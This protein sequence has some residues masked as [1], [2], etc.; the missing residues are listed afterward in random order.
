MDVQS[1]GNITA[2]DFL[3][4]YNTGATINLIDVRRASEYEAQHIAGAVS[5][6][7]DFINQ[8]MSDYKANERYY[9]Q[10]ASGYRSMIAAS[11]LQARG[12]EEVINVQGG[13]KALS[14]L[15]IRMSEY[16]EQQTEL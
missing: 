6:P 13:F 5:L 11:I 7:L 4:L 16:H 9:L 3:K 10:C 1:T 2:K 14:E 12:I 8:H 15:G